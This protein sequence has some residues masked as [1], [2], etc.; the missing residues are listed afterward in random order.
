MC[1]VPARSSNSSILAQIGFSN[2][3]RQQI[4]GYCILGMVAVYVICGLALIPAA[5]LA[6]KLVTGIAKELTF[7]E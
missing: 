2:T 5:G 6:G 1:R 3:R 7:E 4:R